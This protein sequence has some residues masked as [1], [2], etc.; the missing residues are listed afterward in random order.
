MFV[1]RGLKKFRPT[2]RSRLPLVKN[3]SLR[4]D[5]VGLAGFVVAGI[6]GARNVHNPGRN[7]GS[8]VEP[9]NVSVVTSDAPV[10]SRL[11]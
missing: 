8:E 10:C 1:K 9:V 2:K 4:V 6:A 5:A 3:G 11:F 7:R